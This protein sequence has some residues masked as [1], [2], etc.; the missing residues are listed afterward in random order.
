[1]PP[2]QQTRKILV[3]VDAPGVKEA[4]DSI[5]R[6]MGGVS[7]NT[8]SL[9]GNMSF[10]TDTFQTWL[11]FLGVREV[12]R[13]ADEMQ[14]LNNRLKITTKDGESV[15]ET[16]AQLQGLAS[17]TNQSLAGVG[18]VFNRLSLAMDGIKASSAEVLSVSEVLINTFRIAGA[19]TT[20]TANTMIQLSQAFASG[21][22]RGQELRSVME[23]NAVLAKILREEFGTDVYKKAEKGLIKVSDVLELLA[24]NQET[25]LMQAKELAPT[26]EQVLT[27]A[28]DTVA[29]KIGNVNREF[30]GSA[31][32]AKVVEAATSQLGTIL[33]TVVAGAFTFLIG[34]VAALAL[35][36]RA[37]ALTNPWTAAFL[38]LSVVAVSI[39]ENWSKLPEL[40]M[41]VKASL[42]DLAA[43]YEELLL[44]VQKSRDAIFG[45]NNTGRAYDKIAE[46][47]KE[48]KAI[49]DVFEQRKQFQEAEDK[50]DAQQAAKKLREVAKRQKLSEQS[51]GKDKPAKSK[52]LLK[53]LNEEFNKGIVSID[54]YN[55]KIRSIELYRINKDF[56]EGKMNVEQYYEALNKGT[57]QEITRRLNEGT[58]SFNQYSAA[59]EAVKIS[60]LDASLRSGK[61]SLQE[62]NEELV[63]ISSKLEAGGA[64]QAGTSS[65][66]K[67]IGTLSSNIADG[68]KNAFSTLEDTIVDFVK[69]GEFNFKKF[70]ESVL[71]DLTRIIIRAA[72]LRPIT[73]AI[74][75]GAGGAGAAA[76]PA[77]AARGMAFDSGVRKFAQGGI[78]D[79]PTGFTYGGGKRGLMGEAGT[80]AIIPLERAGNGNLGVAATVTPVTINV[81]NQSGAEVEQKESTG[82]N[83]EKTIDILIAGRVREGLLTG[84]FDSAMK[85][86]YGLSRK[87]S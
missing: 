69:T 72:I 46:Y 87:G 41:K 20:E 33:V 86:S 51:K 56:A 22:L 10:L 81:I 66:L 78:V 54:D 44:P 4:L 6:A 62:Y 31:K 80:E 64:L 71:D 59:I 21:E 8:K 3:K 32:F 23:Q 1:M 18:E 26:Y 34:K 30:D 70:T 29:V 17:R 19:T 65:Y 13:M 16:F 60:E 42:Y 28:M 25:V 74:L 82:P 84:K 49:R 57:L 77:A 39:Y 52:D 50:Y 11:G 12:V 67:S 63:K 35:A 47:R 75:G 24:K 85:Q 61:I 83:G 36:L 38:A 53:E 37:F 58:I 43:S 7:K 45:T 79:S 73:G 40:F 48:A 2:Q 76:A 55:D 15:S 5:S 14:N 27:K 68:I 9:A